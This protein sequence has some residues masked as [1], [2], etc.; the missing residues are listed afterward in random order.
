[1]VKKNYESKADKELYAALKDLLKAI[2]I[3]LGY[4]G[5]YYIKEAVVILVKE[6]PTPPKIMTLYERVGEKYNRDGA[7]VSHTIKYAIIKACETGN[8]DMLN[9][10]LPGCISKKRKLPTNLQFLRAVV[11]YIQVMLS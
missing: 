8:Q 10:L 4:R 2:G 6:S 7:T 9:T 11:E 3:P 1:M 5:F